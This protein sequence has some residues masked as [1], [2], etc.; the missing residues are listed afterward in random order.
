MHH[1]RGLQ[2]KLGRH[3][4]GICRHRNRP[5]LETPPEP[6]Q[7][8][9]CLGNEV[10][11]PSPPHAPPPPSPRASHID[12]AVPGRVINSLS[13]SARRRVCQH[14]CID[15]VAISTV[16]RYLD[17][18]ISTSV[19]QH[20]SGTATSVSRHLY[21]GVGISTSNRTS[22]SLLGVAPPTKQGHAP[23]PRQRRKSRQPANARYG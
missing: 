13:A 11:G 19:S 23:P 18:D 15:A 17:V 2:A 6:I 3:K 21:L 16:V 20:R 4:G 9:H 12:P 8:E 5:V 7:C 22:T 10:G 14:R 1:L